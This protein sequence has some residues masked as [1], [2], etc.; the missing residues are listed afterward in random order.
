MKPYAIAAV[1]LLA[2]TTAAYG[3]NGADETYRTNLFAYGGIP[4][5]K[6]SADACPEF[7][8]LVN[9]AYAVGYSEDLKDPVWAVYRLGNRKG[10]TLGV[11][12][13]RPYFFKVDTRTQ[14]KV[15]HDDYTSSGYDRG[16]LAPNAAMLDQYGQLAQLETYFMSNIIPQHRDLNRGIWAAL[17]A[18]VRE[19]IS[20]DDTKDKEIHDVYVIAGPLFKYEADEQLGTIQRMPSGVAIPEGSFKILAYQRG[21]FG[22]I[23]AVAL[24]FPQ[25]P[26]SSNLLDYVVTVDELEDLTGFDFF[27]ELSEQKQRNLES[28]RRNFL[29]E[30]LQ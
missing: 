25:H 17:E 4:V 5:C 7:T 15:T 18:K 30:D 20:Q 19:E 29:L 26:T 28:K 14:A 12:F 21:Y 22:T 24:K 1:L 9:S 6:S 23:K 10:D 3:Q 16:H 2:L 13:E 8:T 11:K 27:P